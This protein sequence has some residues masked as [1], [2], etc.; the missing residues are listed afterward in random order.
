[1]TIWHNIGRDVNHGVWAIAGSRMGTYMTMLTNW[2]YRL[3]QDFDALAE[4]WERFPDLLH[5]IGVSSLIE[6]TAGWEFDHKELKAFQEGLAMIP[7]F[8]EKCYK[9]KQKQTG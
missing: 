5:I 8:L 7:E 4:I 6:W 2:D 1:L 9:E 3:V